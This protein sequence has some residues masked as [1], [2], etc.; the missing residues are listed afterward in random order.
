ML[1]AETI[2]Q[3]ASPISDYAIIVNPRDNVAVVKAKTTADLAV[4]LPNKH[5]VTLKSEIPLGH[6]FATREIPAGEFVLQYGQPIG[7]SLGIGKGELVSHRK[8]VKRCADCPRFA[9]RFAHTG[10]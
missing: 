8:Y 1:I 10:T 5:I 9:R 6:R 7:T 2:T 4:V 3:T